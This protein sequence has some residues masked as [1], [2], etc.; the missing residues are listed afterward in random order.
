MFKGLGN[1]SNIGS[2]LKQAQ[3]IGSRMQGLADELK[4]R[5]ASGTS[6]GGLV[7]VEVNG[8]GEVLTCRIDPSLAGDRELLEDL[9][10]A[11]VNQALEKAKEIHA[12]ALKSMT[13]SFDS[14]DF[15]SMLNEL[16]EQEPPEPP[17]DGS[18]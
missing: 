16:A 18:K 10:P 3:Q 2:F 4:S 7:T 6:G 8:A 1:L 11:A 5:R 17:A 12:E 15:Q 14:P 13:Q 9:V